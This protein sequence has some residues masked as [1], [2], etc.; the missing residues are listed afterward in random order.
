MIAHDRHRWV[1]NPGFPFEQ[2]FS[3]FNPCCFPMETIGAAA[4]SLIP[5]ADV[6]TYATHAA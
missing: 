3:D 2:E 4:I 6:A 1:I 5:A